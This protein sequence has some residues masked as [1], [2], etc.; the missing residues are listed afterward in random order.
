VSF[1]WLNYRY[2]DGRFAGA[3]VIEAT[4][5]VSARMLAA[6][7]GLDEGLNFAGG[8]V[9]DDASANQIP[10]SMIDR[11]LDHRDLR[12]LQRLLLTENPPEPSVKGRKRQRRSGGEPRRTAQHRKTA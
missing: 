3:A 10:E 8:R 4:A 5:L 1:F 12:R 11:L 7:F 9:I 2:P 6:V